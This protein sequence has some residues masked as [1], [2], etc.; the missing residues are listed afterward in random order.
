MAS[1]EDPCLQVKALGLTFPNPLGSAAGLDKD[2]TWSEELGALGFGFVEVGTVT[3]Q[4]QKGNPR[5][6]VWRVPGERALINSLGFPNTGA[7]E[8]ARRLQ[9]RG[10][11]TVVGTSI[12]KSK[13]ASA[14]AAGDDY[15]TTVRHVAQLSDFLVLNVSSPNTPGL[16][17]MQAVDPLKALIKGVQDELDLIG[18]RVPILVKISADL[19]D[20]E[21]DQ[22]ADLC[23]TLGLDGIV[24]V[25]TTVDRSV[26]RS[27]PEHAADWS[28][29]ISGAPLK[30]RAV[31][32]LRQLRARAGDRIVLISVGGIETA[33]D[34]WGRILAG[35]TLIQGYTGFVYGGPLWPRRLNKE[36]ARRVREAD[37][38]SIGEMVGSGGGHIERRK[39]ANAPSRSPLGSTNV[40]E[41]IALT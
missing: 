18:V 2:L 16:Q 21:I 8:A 26:L 19:P 1:Y 32:V 5:P 4:A 11:R 22:V 6:R 30:P 17:D 24:A 34:A 37:A 39:P 14:A 31:E 33:D 25:N 13:S 9:K 3:A 10:G 23:L 20:A 28:G 27:A 35:A 7:E 29:G 15:R 40:S 12:G 36:L 41:N 38:A